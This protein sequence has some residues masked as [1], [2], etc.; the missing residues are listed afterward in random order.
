M[1]EKVTR[2]GLQKAIGC[3]MRTIRLAIASG[4]ITGTKNAKGYWEFD[5]EECRAALRATSTAHKLPAAEELGVPDAERRNLRPRAAVVV[6]DEDGEELG[7]GPDGTLV[8]KPTNIAEARLLRETY[9]AMQAKIDYEKE[10]GLLISK[11]DVQREFED[12]AIKVQR[13]VLSVPPR[14]SAII[15]AETDEFKIQ[16]LL[17]KELTIALRTIA[18]DLKL[19]TP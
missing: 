3:S 7:E 13:G 2:N 14:V 16:A 10:S 17:S 18:N 5:V 11:D 8:G 12:I 1:A 4:R 19:L 15:A 6:N 9:L